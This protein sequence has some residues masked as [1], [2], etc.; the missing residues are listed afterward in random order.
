MGLIRHHPSLFEGFPVGTPRMSREEAALRVAEM[1][2]LVLSHEVRDAARDRCITSCIGLIGWAMKRSDVEAIY[3]QD[4]LSHLSEVLVVAVD[5]F[6]PTQGTDP[7]RNNLSGYVAWK[8]KQETRG[9]ATRFC[10]LIRVPD[11]AVKSTFDQQEPNRPLTRHSRVT[12][13]CRLSAI[14]AMAVRAGDSPLQATDPELFLGAI[15]DDEVEDPTDRLDREETRIRL[16]QEI[17]TLP[18]IEAEVIRASFGIDVTQET[19]RSIGDRISMS[20]SWTHRI[21]K[22]ALERLRSRVTA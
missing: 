5:N 7:E 20:Y 11:G 10:L 15:E 19:L 18:P 21:R 13:R 17:D 8:L 1:W 6:N 14:I 3:F 2:S 4:L 16:R 12:A 9:F 22:R